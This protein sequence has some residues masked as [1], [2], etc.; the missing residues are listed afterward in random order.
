MELETEFS[1]PLIDLVA[2]SQHCGPRPKGFWQ[3]FNCRE[4][5][6][7][8]TNRDVLGEPILGNE[9]SRRKR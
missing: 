8:I 6:K 9:T 3:G 5:E 7:L 2:S 1:A 4:P